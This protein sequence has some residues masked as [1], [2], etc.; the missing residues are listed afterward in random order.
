MVG[1]VIFICSEISVAQQS[2]R[3][4]TLVIKL[5]NPAH[6][7]DEALGPLSSLLLSLYDIDIF[8]E[9][10]PILLVHETITESYK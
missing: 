4:V 5:Y 7:S 2:R 3:V 1:N 10:P 8:L 6:I 9:Q